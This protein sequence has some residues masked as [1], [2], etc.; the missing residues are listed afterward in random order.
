MNHRRSPRPIAGALE[1]AR[2]RWQPATPLGRA[3]SAWSDLAEAWTEAVGAHGSYLVE[4]TEVV[5]MRLGVLT[6]NCAEAV[7]ADTLTLEAELLI[8][9][10]NAS[11]ATERIT[12]LRCV[13][14][15]PR[16]A[17][18]SGLGKSQFYRD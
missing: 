8:K 1:T 4:R 7:V 2:S 5:G 9:R 16:R 18:Q 15:E 12:R 6:V 3:Q 13:V 14:G 10:L 11:L 17:S